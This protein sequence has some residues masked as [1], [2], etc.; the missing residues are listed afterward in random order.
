M[1]EHIDYVE[2]VAKLIRHVAW[3]DSAQVRAK[4]AQINLHIYGPQVGVAANTCCVEPHSIVLKENLEMFCTMWQ[5]LVDDVIHISKQVADQLPNQLPHAVSRGGN[6]GSTAATSLGGGG[7]QIPAVI[8][9]GSEGG[10]L[11]DTSVVKTI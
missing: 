2:D 7:Q 6:R 3:T 10:D 4:H 1:S 9:S 11:V 8:I 5:Y